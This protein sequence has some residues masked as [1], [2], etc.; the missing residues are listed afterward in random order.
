MLSILHLGG[1]LGISGGHLPAG[2]EASWIW[3]SS[4]ML[5]MLGLRGSK[6]VPNGSPEASDA[7][8]PASRQA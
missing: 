7:M 2:F 6:I 3:H 5:S 8:N 1:S 4:P